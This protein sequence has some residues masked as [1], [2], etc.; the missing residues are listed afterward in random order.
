MMARLFA[1]TVF[2]YPLALALLCLGAG[3]LFDRLSGEFLPAAL[4]P[5][6]GAAALIALSQ[7]STYISPLAEATP[8]LLAAVALS[9]LALARSRLRSLVERLR[10]WWWLAGLAALA[11][12]LAI[13]PVLLA[14]RPSFSSFMALSDSAVHLIGADYLIHHGQDYSHLD[15]RNSYGRFIESY[16]ASSYPS[17]ADTLFGGSALLLR[18]PLIWS[19]QPFNALMLAIGWGPAWLLARS[20]GLRGAWA[21]LAALSAIVPALVYGYELIGSVKEITVLSMVL[22]L[23]ALVALHRRW[24]S[25]EPLRAVPFALVVAAGVSAIGVGFGAW[26]LAAAGVL[27]V[28][29]VAEGRAGQRRVAEALPTVALGALVLLVV[30]WPTWV[31]LSGSLHVAQNVA[32]SGNPGN[33]P[34][35]LKWTQALGVW[36]HGS[37]KQ[38][39]AG[40]ALFFTDVLIA[41]TLAA[42]ALGAVHVLRI[43]R[44]ALAGWIALMLVVWLVLSSYSTTWVSAKSLMISSPVVVLLA[45]G[46]VA[47]LLHAGRSVIARPSAGS[48]SA[49]RPSA[50]GLL[51]GRAALA[52]L[53][54]VAAPLLALVLAGGVLASDATQYHGSNLAP[55]ARYDELASLN[56]RFAR[57]GPA[58]FTDFDEYSMYELRNVDVGGPDFV[59]PPPALARLAGGYGQPVELD[60]A[61]PDALR[62]YPLIVTRRDPSASPPPAAYRLAWQGAYYDVW[63]R[64]RDAAAAIRHEATAD[65]TPLACARVQR[66]A[67]VAS[68]HGLTAVGALAPQ[69][70]HVSL[71]SA[72]RP[73]GWGRQRNGFAMRRA[74]TLSA[75]FQLPRG[76]G[77]ELWLQGQFMP[78][79]RVSVD[80]HPRATIAGQLA[81]NSLVP[82]T[83]TPIRVLL[84]AGAHSVSVTRAGF[85]LAPGSGG[86]AVLDGIFLTR[87][88]T[89]ARRLRTLPP[90]GDA[91]SLCAHH[92][93][94]IEL[95]GSIGPRT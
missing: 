11:Y 17:G 67:R 79:V 86:S 8:Y 26:A 30:A 37:Y 3:L 35:P 24:L 94:W 40:T 91:R 12:L 77:W 89:P 53:R 87:A 39:P 85:S 75:R 5:S 4:L 23:G 32:S 42:C 19:F 58:L 44:Y 95:V 78:E 57:R 36:L 2:A 54:S 84:S 68:A 7:L 13:A 52:D 34:A 92:Y 31:H 80:G 46:G 29:L 73:A 16:Y 28:V 48:A 59:F 83:A 66:T 62:A 41:V 55:T 43:R 71:H 1:L 76:G 65:R 72:S 51:A 27:L 49:S 47:A 20:I 70:V 38:S 10:A 63:D 45:W 93:A 74:G 50:G 22:T 60:R 14:G 33:L 69:V 18:L 90:A 88:G 82:D 9:G 6:V 64:R 21:A 81:G 15:L 25:R 56:D 61:S